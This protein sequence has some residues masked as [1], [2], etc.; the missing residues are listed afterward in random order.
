MG[1]FCFSHSLKSLLPPSNKKRL[2]LSECVHKKA[3]LGPFSSS[4]LRALPRPTEPWC[5]NQKR[6]APIWGVPPLPVSHGS[7]VAEPRGCKER[8][9]GL[10]GPRRRDLALGGT[11]GGSSAAAGKQTDCVKD[12]VS[13]P[14]PPP[15][16]AGG[17][18]G[19]GG[20]RQGSAGV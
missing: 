2:H 19:Q 9:R 14:S 3:E 6:R 4:L 11:T 8:W 10:E 12:A 15:S 17:A 7:A 16:L 20:R 13:T 1:S 5:H 18:R